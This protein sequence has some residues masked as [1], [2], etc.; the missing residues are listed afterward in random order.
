[1]SAV[2]SA[3]TSRLR[4]ISDV[5]ALCS[6][7]TADTAPWS[8]STVLTACEIRAT[9]LCTSAASRVTA[10]S[11]GA[12]VP[13]ALDVCWARSLTSPATTAKPAPADPARAASMVAFRASRWV[14][15]AMAVTVSRTAAICDVDAASRSAAPAAASVMPTACAAWPDA[16]VTSWATDSMDARISVIAAVTVCT[17]ELT[18]DA[19]PAAPSARDTVRPAA[20]SSVPEDP[21]SRPAV[22][23]TDSA[24]ARIRLSAA[25]IASMASP[26]AVPM[27]PISSCPSP[28]TSTDRSRSATRRR[29]SVSR[30]TRPTTRPEIHT[31]SATA[32]TATTRPTT[33]SVR[34]SVADPAVSSSETAR[35]SASR[36]HA[37]TV[38]P[39]GAYRATC[40]VAA[41]PSPRSTRSVA[42]SP[43]AR[44][45]AAATRR[46]PSAAAVPG[47]GTT[48]APASSATVRY[49]CSPTA[50]WAS[51]ARS[52]SSTSA[53]GT[54]TNSAP[55]TDPSTRSGAYAV[56]YGWPTTCAV[57]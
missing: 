32:S 15:P 12:M 31:T 47:G 36:P 11:T 3:A 49:P 55:A 4:S 24:P 35:R 41:A 8:P 17:S 44:S 16:A 19:E 1:M 37:A 57:P 43:S 26:S 51:A 13:I 21:S 52:G 23:R 2:D 38:H 29:A 42:V 9:A 50:T 34:T 48:H 25:C 20:A 28:R 10:S 45:A 39:H 53:C 22:L 18:T 30:P 5:V 40:T 54:P 46:D 27:T 6:S 7:T 33:S 56:T 14:C